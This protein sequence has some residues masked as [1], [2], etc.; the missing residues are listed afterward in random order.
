MAFVG[1]RGCK[2]ATL[3]ASVDTRAI[4]IFFLKVHAVSICVEREG[5]CSGGVRGYCKWKMTARPSGLADM[6]PFVL[7][8]CI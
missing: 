3:A 7:G 6:T 5:G 1:V 8:P 4:S 2:A